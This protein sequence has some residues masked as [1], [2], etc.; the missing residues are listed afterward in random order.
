MPRINTIFLS[1][2]FMIFLHIVPSL[3]NHPPSPWFRNVWIC[4]EENWQG[5]CTWLTFMGN[6][7]QS[8]DNHDFAWYDN[9]DVGRDVNAVIGS[10]GPDW[11]RTSSL[12][13]SQT[14]EID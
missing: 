5:N 4:N 1:L 12:L 9:S 7:P 11:V 2:T 10:F 14:P 13:V 6:D 8:T 3:C